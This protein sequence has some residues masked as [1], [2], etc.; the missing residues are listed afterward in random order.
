MKFLEEAT[1]QE[2]DLDDPYWGIPDDGMSR[3]WTP[4]PEA[5]PYENLGAR[6]AFPLQADVYLE[7]LNRL[8]GIRVFDRTRLKVLVDRWWPRSVP[9]RRFCLAF[10][11]LHGSLPTERDDRIGLRAQTPVEFLILCVLHTEKIL[12]DAYLATAVTAATVPRLGAGAL[13]KFSAEAVLRSYGFRREQD[14][15]QELASLLKRKSQL[16][17]LPLNP[18]NPFVATTAF[19]WG[20]DLA[21]Q[22]LT[23]FA[24][25]VI[26]RNYA[27]HHDCLDDQL[28]YAP[29]AETALE[30]VLIPVLTILAAR[31]ESR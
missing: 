19:T 6:R 13:A 12:R 3:G 28:V 27:A 11:R 25:F 17:T 1:D 16:Y 4:L 15:S 24:N 31:G 26:L 22:L 14:G 18:R 30:A 5:L 9:L 2:V 20:D 23:A 7:D 8:N 21:K 10:H 29:M